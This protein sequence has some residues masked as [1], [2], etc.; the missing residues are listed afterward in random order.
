VL[1]HSA[2]QGKHVKPILI[3]ISGIAAALA[4]VIEG[5]SSPPLNSS[6]LDVWLWTISFALF[7]SL[8]LFALAAI[9][10]ARTSRLSTSRWERLSR[11][12][13]SSPRAALL[14]WVAE[15]VLCVV[16]VFSGAWYC[17]ACEGRPDYRAWPTFVATAL[18]WALALYA[19]LRSRQKSN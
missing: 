7:A 15:L 5:N 13:T 2:K 9:R 10:R 1:G 19:F 3:V 18:P 6:A 8:P 4:I 11:P 12:S 17:E 16:Y 14:L